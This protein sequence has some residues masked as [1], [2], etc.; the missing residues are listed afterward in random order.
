MWSMRWL[1]SKATVRILVDDITTLYD[2]GLIDAVP[3]RIEGLTDERL[4]RPA[5]QAGPGLS[6][7][8][9]QLPLLD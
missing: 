4:P 9:V 1:T 6:K 3:V 7:R 2:L 8:G 5:R